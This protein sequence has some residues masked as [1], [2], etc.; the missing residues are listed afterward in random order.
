MD[1]HFAS[2]LWRGESAKR[3]KR[4]E[5]AER[6]SLSDAEPLSAQVGQPSPSDVA[7]PGADRDGVN[8]FVGDVFGAV[9]HSDRQLEKER[10][11]LFARIGEAYDQIIKYLSA[12]FYLDPDS[13]GVI[14]RPTL[15]PYWHYL[16]VE[17]SE[18][19]AFDPATGQIAS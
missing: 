10:D 11:T 5:A 1:L 14:A 6:L 9:A 4:P 17:P 7:T 19:S 3:S 8:E 16:F 15:G 2:S 18:A 12:Y 13:P